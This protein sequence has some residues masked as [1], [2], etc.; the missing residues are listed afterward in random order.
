VDRFELMHINNDFVYQG[1]HDYD[2]LF[3]REDITDRVRAHRRFMIDQLDRFKHLLDEPQPERH[4]G[5]YCKHPYPCPY[6]DYCTRHDADYPVAWLP[7]GWRIAQTMHARDIHD[8][9]DIPVDALTSETHLRV[10]SVTIS[11]VP[12]L[13]PGAQ[14]ILN[15][16]EYPRYYV[17]F[18]C[19]Q[20][21]IPIWTGTQP[22]QQ[23]PFQWSCHVQTAK[24]HLEHREFLDVTGE[25]PRRAFAES[26][27]QACG[28]EGPL[29][30]YNQSFEKRILK[31]LTA[32]FPD[33]QDDLMGLHDRVFDL[34]PVVRQ[35]YY[36][37][38]MQG[39]WSI[40]SV[41]PCL[42][43]ELRYSELGQVQDG[44]QA[45]AGYLDLIGDEL[46]D[47]QKENLH[48]DLIEYCKLDTYAMVAIAEQL[49]KQAS[50]QQRNQG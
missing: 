3:T 45:Q 32:A 46:T 31:E 48:N 25:D 21:A 8:I 20:F 17:D 50:V 11:G 37:P 39:S 36:H 49:V 19:I 29:V 4:I 28:K 40:K 16:L 44:T 1:G 34:L 2:G 9:R 41:L 15:G 23:L 14:T 30:V 10:R 26:L 43:P 18:E 12:E 5:S 22:F 24:G 33:L 47:Q 35:H 6:R 7:N 13:L 42:V 27:L 38:D